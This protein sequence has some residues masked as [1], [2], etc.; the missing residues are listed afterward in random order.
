MCKRRSVEPSSHAGQNIDDYPMLDRILGNNS[1]P[2]W[3]IWTPAPMQ[4][5]K[6]Q[7]M[8]AQLKEE[9][10]RL[11]EREPADEFHACVLLGALNLVEDLLK[12]KKERANCN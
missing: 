11:L 5:K 3:N 8:L 6:M 1:E 4:R 10:A 7:E 9:H 12:S 2:F